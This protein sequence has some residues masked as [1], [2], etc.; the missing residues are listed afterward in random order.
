MTRFFYRFDSDRDED[1]E[2]YGPTG[3]FDDI[4]SA[5]EHIMDVHSSSDQFDIWDAGDFWNRDWS[6]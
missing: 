3:H 6:R 5:V 2:I 1:I 4:D